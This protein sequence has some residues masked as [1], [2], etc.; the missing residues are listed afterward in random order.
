MHLQLS[1]WLQCRGQS[2]ADCAFYHLTEPNASWPLLV[3]DFDCLTRGS[4]IWM[5]FLAVKSPS[6]GHFGPSTFNQTRW[7]NTKS[8]KTRRFLENNCFFFCMEKSRHWFLSSFPWMKRELGAA[9]VRLDGNFFFRKYKTVCARSCSLGQYHVELV[10]YLIFL[11]LF[12]V[13]KITNQKT[14]SKWG[15]YQFYQLL[16]WSVVL[17]FRFCY[18]S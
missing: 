5:I 8:H 10:I 11:P 18:P 13:A 15:A 14:W 16:I 9:C 4:F 12:L 17:G 2:G 7:K 6:H 1:L 3:L